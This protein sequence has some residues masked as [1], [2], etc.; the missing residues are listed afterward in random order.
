MVENVDVEHG[1]PSSWVTRAAERAPSVQN[2][3][4][5][6]MQRAQQIVDAARRLLTQR[7]GDFTTHELVREAGIAIQTL[8]KHFP[9]K[10]HVMLAVLEDMIGEGVERYRRSGAS[11]QDPLE[12]LRFYVY[13]VFEDLD[14]PGTSF[15]PA[16]HWRLIQ[17]Y[18]DEVEHA[19]QPVA[20]L[21]AAALQEA[22]QEGLVAPADIEQAAWF[23]NQ[24]LLSTFHHLSFATTRESPDVVAANLWA[25]LLPAY[26]GG[27][28][29]RPALPP[30]LP[31][32]VAEVAAG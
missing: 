17:L 30:P 27:P 22:A 32:A 28:A 10:D 19:R 6:S 16:E 23:T 20:E 11:I 29:P 4:L 5:R 9:S 25:F 31:G 12:R 14:A 26:G 8:Y 15:I 18:P 2:S 21:F 1:P 13:S 7:P 3:R 24:L